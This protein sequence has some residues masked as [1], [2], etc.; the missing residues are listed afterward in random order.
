MLP[1]H[2]VHNVRQIYSL[3]LEDHPFRNSV[4]KILSRFRSS[5]LNIEIKI[6]LWKISDLQDQINRLQHSL[7]ENLRPQLFTVLMHMATNV[8]NDHFKK[9]KN[10]NIKKLQDLKCKHGL[11]TPS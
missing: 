6:C 4:H 5:I 8:Y 3:E 1:N 10:L 2:I 11:L 7:Q 9:V